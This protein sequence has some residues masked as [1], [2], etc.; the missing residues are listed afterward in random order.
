MNYIYNSCTYIEY[1]FEISSKRTISHN[2]S[3]IEYVKYWHE[4]IS[5]LPKNCKTPRTSYR[6]PRLVGR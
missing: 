3:T 4:K 5:K 6:G 2:K 1:Y